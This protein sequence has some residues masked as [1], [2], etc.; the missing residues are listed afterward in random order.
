MKRL[1]RKW[2]FVGSCVLLLPLCASAEIRIAVSTS[3]LSSPFYIAEKQGYFKDEGLDI[4]IIDM[5][6][7]HRCLVAMLENKA[8]LA[9]ASDSPI[10]VQSFKHDDFR[11]LATFVTSYNDVKLVTKKS[12]AIHE[13]ADLSGKT[14]GIIEGSSSQYFLEKFVIDHGINPDR[15]NMV[16]IKPGDMPDALASGK[17]DVISVWEPYGYISKQ[18][19]SAEFYIVP[20]RN[21]YR[22]TFNLTAKQAFI[23][24]HEQD[25]EKIL[26]AL[27]KA[28]NFIANETASAK[29]IIRD[30]LNL[31]DAFIDWIW[32]DF[33]FRLSLDQLLLSTLESE[34]NWL[35]RRNRVQTTTIPVYLRYI[36]PRYLKKV[37]PDAV[38]NL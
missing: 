26:R 17:V 3:P 10:A 34:A 37:A 21:T 22:E 29:V 19:F 8:D 16:H 4:T 18:R 24:L 25:I 38:F 28:E 12:A 33:S 6:G 9:T 23:K 1:I 36:E 30:R 7:G 13:A 27:Q 11:I 5:V 15:V 2:L 31:D 32:D 14:V 35:I 20:T